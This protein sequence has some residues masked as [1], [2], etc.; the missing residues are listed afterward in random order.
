MSERMNKF[1]VELGELLEYQNISI[2]EYAERIGTTPKNLI[3]IIDGKVSLSLNIICNIAFVSNIPVNYITNVETSFKIDGRIDAFLQDNKMTIRDFINRCDYKELKEKYNVN[4]SNDLNDYS[5]ARDILKYLKMT[6]PKLIYKENNHIFYKSKNDKPEL[7]ALW[8]EHCNRV[9]SEQQIGNY[10]KSNIDILVSYIYKSAKE[11]TFNKKEL[12]DTFN[13][14]GI[15]LAIESDLKGS[16][17]RG[18]FVV[19][20]NKPAIYITT[21]HK[22]LADIYFALLHELA[23]CKSDFN[24]A[25]NG[26]I[27]SYL[28]DKE[29][30]DYEKKADE[31]ALNWMVN[32]KEYSDIIRSNKLEHDNMTFLV[33]RLALDGIISYSSKLY[34]TNNIIMTEEIL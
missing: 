15:Y 1:G 19:H 16:K 32:N 29:N 7:L 20:N 4:Y 25:K 10:N 11:K 24:R 23:H 30:E 12:I 14:Y 2:N 18:A 9:I 6:D 17:I 21:K 3:D 8:L 22:R 28:D 27:V 33:Y 34:Q 26:S 31:C 13:K 5:I